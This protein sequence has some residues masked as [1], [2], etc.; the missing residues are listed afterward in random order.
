MRKTEK[1]NRRGDLLPNSLMGWIL[2]LLFFVV[3]IGAVI[4]LVKKL[5]G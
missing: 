1:M 5:I 3:A 2:F 4:L